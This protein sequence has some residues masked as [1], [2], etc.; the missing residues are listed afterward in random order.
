MSSYEE[1]AHRAW[2]SGDLAS[3]FMCFRLGANGGQVGCMMNLGYFY[4][5]GVGTLRSKHD[6]MRW[7]KRAFLN[8]DSS[9]ASN[10]AILFRERGNHRQMFRWFVA[11]ARRD[12]GDALVEV[13]KCYLMGLGVPRS[14]MMTIA[15]AH[16]ALRSAHISPA[17]REEAFGLLAAL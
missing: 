8:G 1:E 10:I 17:G 16:K 11:A 14:T 9:A 3:A 13:A 7:Y 4:D 15:N 12:D 5:E 2:E 6:A